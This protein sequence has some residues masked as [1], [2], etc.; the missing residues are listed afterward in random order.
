MMTR[1]AALFAASGLMRAVGKRM[2]QREKWVHVKLP[3]AERNLWHELAADAGVSLADFVRM[4][5]GEA[6]LT[7]RLPTKKQPVKRVDPE[8]IRQISRVGA[9]VNQVARWA[10]FYKSEA[11]AEQVLFALLKIERD[12]AEVRADF[13]PNARRE[14]IADDD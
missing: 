9:N 6:K 4:R 3:A 14:I 7:R 2:A 10:N 13:M 12:L 5:V 11:D 1:Q 8:L